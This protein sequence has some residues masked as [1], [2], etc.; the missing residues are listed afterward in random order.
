MCYNNQIKIKPGGFGGF[1]I[2]LRI[3]EFFRASLFEIM[4][5]KV[6]HVLESALLFFTIIC[7]SRYYSYPVYY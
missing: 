2:K 4:F 1:A 3:I 6:G 7:W 5:K